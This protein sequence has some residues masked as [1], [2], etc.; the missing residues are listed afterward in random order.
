MG[1]CLG[2]FLLNSLSR[3]YVAYEDEYVLKVMDT[4]I[5]D[6]SLTICQGDTVNGHTETGMYIDTF[7]VNEPND[8]ILNLSLFVIQVDTLFLVDTI[9]GGDTIL[10]YLKQVFI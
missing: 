6:L 9:C 4:T 3:E 8:S 5:T 7:T 1:L 10:G 2:L